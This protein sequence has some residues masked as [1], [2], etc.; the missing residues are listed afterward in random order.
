MDLLP[1]CR[2]P[3]SPPPA[4]RTSTGTSRTWRR[5][6][7]GTLNSCHAHVVESA[8]T[9]RF[10]FFWAMRNFSQH[11]CFPPRTVSLCS[12]FSYQ[13]INEYWYANS[14]GNPKLIRNGY[15]AKTFFYYVSF[16][17]FSFHSWP[18]QDWRSFVSVHAWEIRSWCIS[19]SLS[20][21]S[22]PF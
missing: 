11:Q 7:S 21:F 1:S 3:S 10:F 22:F 5:T 20:L 18:E 8:G 9:V 13:W 19:L 17:C 16:C 12:A 4:P 2:W 6:S 14:F 15:E